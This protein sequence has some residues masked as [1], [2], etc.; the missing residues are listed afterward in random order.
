MRFA[1]DVVPAL[2][3]RGVL[4]TEYAGDTLRAHLGPPL[5][6]N[7]YTVGTKGVSA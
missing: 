5:P 2:Q 3:K 6:V 1:D 7:R 4:R